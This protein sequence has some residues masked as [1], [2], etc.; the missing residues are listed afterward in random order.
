MQPSAE[1]QQ[2]LRD[3]MKEAE[4]NCAILNQ[5]RRRFRCCFCAKIFDGYGNN[6]EP[7]EPVEVDPLSD[8]D[9]VCCDGCNSSIVVPARMYVMTKE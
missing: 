7:V 3:L 4:D 8:T 2:K 9:P 6:P 5:R 1:D